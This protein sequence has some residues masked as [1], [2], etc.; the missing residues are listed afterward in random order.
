M[1][2]DWSCNDYLPAVLL[3]AGA[4]LSLEPDS[5]LAFFD[6]CDLWLLLDLW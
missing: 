6:L 2:T 4:L 3:E 5:L 1:P